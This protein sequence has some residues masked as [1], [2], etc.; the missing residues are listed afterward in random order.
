M[1]YVL[2]CMHSSFE[3]DKVEL[4]KLDCCS[5]PPTVTHTIKISPYV[6]VPGPHGMCCVEEGNKTLIVT[7]Q[8]LTGLTAY[9]TQTG[10]IEWTIAGCLEDGKICPKLRPPKRGLTLTDHNVL[11]FTA[12]TTDG[13]GHIFTSDLF[14]KCIHMFSSSGEYMGD[15]SVKGH[16]LNNNK[17][18]RIQW[19]QK[20][21]AL[22]VSFKEDDS[23][24]VAW[25]SVK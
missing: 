16:N 24:K 20:T 7:S 10:E 2:W 3:D 22:I 13:Q 15:L 17:P 8:L 5:S 25:V 1:E 14:N 6:H 9:N 18:R 23:A 19:C 12:V 4:E 11:N 21:A